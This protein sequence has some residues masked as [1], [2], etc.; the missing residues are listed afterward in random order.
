[1]KAAPLIGAARTDD[2]SG[3]QQLIVLS[4]VENE[5]DARI[6]TGPLVVMPL[7]KLPRQ[8]HRRNR[9]T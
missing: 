3:K 8:E 9:L 6:E 2:Y 5:P 1:V 7:V 4:D